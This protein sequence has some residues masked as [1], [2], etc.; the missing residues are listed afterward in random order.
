MTDN[1]VMYATSITDASAIDKDDD[2]RCFLKKMFGAHICD[3]CDDI[4]PPNDHRCV[5]TE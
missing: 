1:K 4:C 3:K 2:G 5:L